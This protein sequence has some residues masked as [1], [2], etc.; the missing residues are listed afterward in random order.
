MRVAN[1]VENASEHEI[2]VD[3]TV[4]F[5][6][7]FHHHVKGG[8][9]PLENTLH[10]RHDLITDTGPRLV[11]ITQGESNQQELFLHNAVNRYV[12]T[13]KV[14]IKWLER[15]NKDV[16]L[17]EDTGCKIALFQ[18]N[19]ARPGRTFFNPTIAPGRHPYND[20]LTFAAIAL[21]AADRKPTK[22]YHEASHLC[23]NSRCFADNHLVW[24]DIGSNAKRN[25]CH[26]YGE[27]CN[28]VPACILQR[29]HHRTLISSAV[30][31]AR[32]TKK[33]KK[34]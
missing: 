30:E 32:I 20:G 21:H 12:P 18:P 33:Q 29:S 11:S 17:L 22:R 19:T 4:P 34:Q 14:L 24:E 13:Q 5:V 9:Q 10:P 15:A 8:L 2:V 28:C 26:L 7:P 16:L 1:Q 31:H 3:K 23:G 27:P 6:F 25:L